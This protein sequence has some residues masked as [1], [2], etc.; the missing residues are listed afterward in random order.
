MATAARSRR[1]MSDA[2]VK[3]LVQRTGFE[4][5]TADLRTFT[6]LFPDARRAV[7][8]LAAT[9]YGRLLGEG[10]TKDYTRFSAE[11]AARLPRDYP[12]HAH[13][14]RRFLVRQLLCLLV[15]AL[16]AARDQWRTR[17]K[18]CGEYWRFSAWMRAR[19]SRNRLSLS[20]WVLWSCHK[21]R[22][23]FLSSAKRGEYGQAS[24]ARRATISRRAQRRGRARSHNA[25]RTGEAL[26]ICRPRF[27][28]AATKAPS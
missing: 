21:K 24:W 18:R 23:A 16:R 14:F 11:L 1:A 27:L 8:F 7:E 10:G 17:S 25:S 9:T 4:L 5:R 28:Y 6:S 19:Q 20:A 26:R 12:R 22:V 3:S 13:R 15:P 2:E